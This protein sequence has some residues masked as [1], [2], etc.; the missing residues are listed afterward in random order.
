MLFRSLFL[1]ACVKENV[2]KIKNQGL[3]ST[4]TEKY[5]SQASLNINIHLITSTCG[6]VVKAQTSNLVIYRGYMTFSLMVYIRL[7]D[8]TAGNLAIQK[9]QYCSANLIVFSEKYI[10]HGFMLVL[11]TCI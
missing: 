9:K 1:S 6:C 10:K 8:M 11:Q 5:V 4:A 7:F 2:H 3:I